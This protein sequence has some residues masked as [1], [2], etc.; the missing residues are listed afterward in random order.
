MKPQGASRAPPPAASSWIGVNAQHP[1]PVVRGVCAHRIAPR[2][3]SAGSG[4]R[5][6]SDT[7]RFARPLLSRPARWNRA[8]GFGIEQAR[9]TRDPNG[10]GHASPSHGG[11]GRLRALAGLAE[12]QPARGRAVQPRRW[13]SCHA[14]VRRDGHTM[15]P[16]FR[17]A[18]S[19]PN[20]P[21]S[22]RPPL[23]HFVRVKAGSAR[24][25]PYSDRTSRAHRGLADGLDGG[26]RAAPSRTF[27]AT[28][29]RAAIFRRAH[30]RS[31]HREAK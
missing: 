20:C 5:E 15:S 7:F 25:S 10:A 18:D 28:R 9:R 6:D 11:Q 8:V 14:T 31:L 30:P 12:R 29:L 3:I 23:K 22:P 24:S 2:V 13:P 21:N 1:S 17:H 26:G 27:D 4:N 19:Q 16:P